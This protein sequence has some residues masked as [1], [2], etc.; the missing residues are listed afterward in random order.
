MPVSAALVAKVEAPEA[1]V[2]I[3][4]VGFFVCPSGNGEVS[5]GKFLNRDTFLRNR[6]RLCAKIRTHEHM[7]PH[8]FFAQY[9]C[10]GW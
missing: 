7:F 4:G 5:R 10:S 2:L 6:R 1:H 9:R 3:T 8:G